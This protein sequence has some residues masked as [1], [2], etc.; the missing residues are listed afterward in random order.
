[1]FGSWSVQVKEVHPFTIH[2]DRYF[3]LHVVK[4]SEPEGPVI[5]LKVPLHAIKGAALQGGEKLSVSFLAGQ[6]TSA[7]LIA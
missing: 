3:E 4:T 2:G 5:S 7:K 1:M 6:V